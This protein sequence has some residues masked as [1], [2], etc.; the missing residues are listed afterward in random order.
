MTNKKM[1]ASWANTVLFT[2]FI[3]FSSI[4]KISFIIGSSLAFFSA[5]SIITPLAGAFGGISGSLFT[6]GI[7]GLLRW[8][9]TASLPWHFLA[10]HI[11]GL[12]ASLFWATSSRIKGVPAF[13]CIVLFL[14]HP[15][16]VQAALYTLFWLIP[17]VITISKKETLFARA[18]GSTF[19]AHAVGTVIWLYTKSMNPDIFLMLIPVVIIERVLFA[20]GMVVAYYCIA[21]LITG[22]KQRNAFWTKIIAKVAHY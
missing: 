21:R 15:V 22:Y 10:Y 3:K 9:L 19:T 5:V 8:F 16:G 20:S 6:F 1:L 2:I 12:F 13:C 14:L 11:P 4:A 18:L 17:L 7:V